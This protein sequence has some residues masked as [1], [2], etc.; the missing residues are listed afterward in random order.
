[1]HPLSV[2]NF[3]RYAQDNFTVKPAFTFL[4]G[5]GLSYITYRVDHYYDPLTLKL[6]L[7]PT[8]GS[9]GSDNLLSAKVLSQFPKHRLDDCL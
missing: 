9:P 3:L 1:M 6:N 8:F 5:K 2:K 7:I 4:I